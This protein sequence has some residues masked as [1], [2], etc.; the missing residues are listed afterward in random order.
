MQKIIIAGPGNSGS[1]AVFDFL[2]TREDIFLPFYNQEFRLVNDPEGISDLESSFY[3][4][5]SING[6]NSICMVRNQL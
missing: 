2:K 1:G 6:T 3:Y 4:N 5:F